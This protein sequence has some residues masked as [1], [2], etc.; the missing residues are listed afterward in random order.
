VLYARK[1]ASVGI[2]DIDTA[3]AETVVAE[4]AAEAAEMGTGGKAMAVSCNVT[5]S[6]SVGEAFAA[7]SEAYGGI[8]I[9]VNNAGIGHV[10]T[11]ETTEEADMDRMFAVNVK[12]VFICTKAAVK[13]MM[14]PKAGTGGEDGTPAVPRGGSIVNLA[15]IASHIGLADRTAYSMSKGA[16]WTLTL[17][18]ATDYVRKGIRCNALAPAR[19][20]TPFVDAYLAKNYADTRD[21]KF[22]ELSEYQPC[23]R[24]GR[25]EEIAAMALY[26]AADESSF[27]T[28]A[29]LP[30]DG[31]VSAVM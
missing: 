9:L 24:M 31:G 3:A 7:V 29:L 4:I 15:S 1:G 2:L 19:V 27:V 21:A 13:A 12:G 11:I 28:G 18:T 16:V 23:G 8:D 20:H 14:L 26:L 10:G 6:E 22:K 17:S 5:S 25:P 30:I